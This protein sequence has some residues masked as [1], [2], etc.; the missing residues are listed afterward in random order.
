MVVR[1]QVR[2]LLE[3][4]VG[5]RD[6]HRVAEVLQVLQRKLLHLVRGVA[7]LEVRAQ[8]VALDGLGQ[9]HRRLTL[10]L[11]RGAVGGVDLAV[12]VAAALEVPDLLRRSVGS[13][14][15]LVRGSRPKKWSRT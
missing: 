8:R 1:R 11:D 9:D 15:A 4:G 3:L 7:A 5:D 10:V 14:S 13:T 6:P 12:V 2:V